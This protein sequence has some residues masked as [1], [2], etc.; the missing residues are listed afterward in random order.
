MTKIKIQK[1][2]QDNHNNNKKKRHS[3]LLLDC[4]ESKKKKEE[5]ETNVL[6]V[7]NPKERMTEGKKKKREKEVGK[8]SGRIERRPSIEKSEWRGFPLF[9]IMKCGKTTPFLS[10]FFQCKHLCRYF[11]YTHT[12][13][14]T[15]R[16]QWLFLLHSFL[17][18]LLFCS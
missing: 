5:E 2:K 12:H 18:L 8:T 7:E 3:V 4:C 1:I 11:R 10:L 9:T 17:L 6:Y 16:T 15:F 13:T 14:H